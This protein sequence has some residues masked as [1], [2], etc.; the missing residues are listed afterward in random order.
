MKKTLIAIAL[1]L[2]FG[3]SVP[4]AD[5]FTS[6]Y[7]DFWAQ[8]F[9]KKFSNQNFAEKN[10][11]PYFIR[12]ANR[13]TFRRNTS[14]RLL[15]RRSLFSR[16]FTRRSF[17]RTL[18][19][20]TNGLV[21]TISSTAPNQN[22]YEVNETPINV[23]KLGI[24]NNSRTSSLRLP[25]T[26]M[27]DKIEFQLFS[28]NG[29]FDDASDFDLVVN[30]E[31]FSFDAEG[32]VTI[33][34]NN[35]R[36]AEGE[37]LAL[38]IAIKADDPSNMRHQNG[39]A[40]LRLLN[41]S[42]Y[43]EFSRNFIPVLIR[44]NRISKLISYSPVSVVTGGGNSTIVST[45]NSSI[46]GDILVAG[47][48]KFVLALSFNAL[49]DDIAIRKI[50]VKNILGGHLIDSQIE[51]IQAINLLT[52][53]LLGT[54]R[55][56]NGQARFQ[57]SPRVNIARNSRGKIGFKVKI[58]E[59]PRNNGDRRFALTVFPSDV[60]AESLSTGRELPDGNKN[61]NIDSKTFVVMETKLEITWNNYQQPN[62]FAVGINSPDGIF[63]FEVKNSRDSAELAR[64]SFNV[65]PSGLQFA[66]GSIS[67]D[68]FELVEI[69]GNHEESLNTNISVVG[70]NTVVVDFVNPL[71]FWRNSAKKF[72]L[73]AAL[74]E[75]GA[76][77]NH[78]GVS[79]RILE[80]GNYIN[81][82]LAGVRGSGANFIWSDESG[83]YHSTTSNDWFSGYK[84]D[85]PSSS[86]FVER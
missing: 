49:Y 31:N 78:D 6:K 64:I 3:L 65:Y 55:F 11:S 12:T 63:D 40:K 77:N 70:G 48:E 33:Q 71:D 36:L 51:E 25:K 9:G 69:I 76:F 20:N 35:A 61:F 66:G 23:F 8:L 46:Y 53:E 86:V 19:T 45:A 21:A 24:R 13:R 75:L 52:G 50:T 34:F 54:S 58:R 43:E 74:D 29:I 68:D 60:L 80:D 16:R 4:T 18:T 57:F 67:A 22:I 17:S 59:N 85:V 7:H 14:S 5:A 38:D 32:K 27:L 10:I 79:V 26:I 37:N 47:E 81:N 44:G 39:S 28:K 73:K 56:T 41:I 2:T 15:K 42:A 83:D 62:N 1:I 82:T 84:L 72:R 30:G